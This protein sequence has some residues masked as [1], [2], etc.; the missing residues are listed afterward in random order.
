[1]HVRYFGKTR[2][3]DG[4]STVVDLTLKNFSLQTCGPFQIKCLNYDLSTKK[5]IEVER[6]T[7]DKI[8]YKIVPCLYIHVVSIKKLQVH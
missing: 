7:V 3:K 8:T 6:Q 1:M 2:H 4:S 5:N